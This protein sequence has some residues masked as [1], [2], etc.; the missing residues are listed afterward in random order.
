MSLCSEGWDHAA[1]EAQDKER[2]AAW[3][4]DLRDAHEMRKHVA[5]QLKE[6]EAELAEARELN[7]STTNEHRLWLKLRAE[8]QLVILREAVRAIAEACPTTSIRQRLR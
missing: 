7:V 6:R 3:R 8:A 5:A 2:E 4:E 1:K